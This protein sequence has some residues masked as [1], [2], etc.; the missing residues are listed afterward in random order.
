MKTGRLLIEVGRLI[1]V[2][3]KF[4][5][6]AVDVVLLF[7]YNKTLVEKCAYVKI[8]AKIIVTKQSKCTFTAVYC[9]GVRSCNK[10]IKSFAFPTERAGK[11]LVHVTLGKVSGLIG[12]LKVHCPCKAH[13][14]CDR[15]PVNILLEQI[16][17]WPLNTGKKAVSNNLATTIRV[18]MAAY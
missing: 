12:D 13:D 17:C 18:A 6:M 2:Q 3:Y 10:D 14:S 16:I 15:L 8:N 7:L 4:V 1:E 9:C 11:V 5:E